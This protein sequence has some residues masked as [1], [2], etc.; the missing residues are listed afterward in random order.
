[1]QVLIGRERS[2]L[3]TFKSLHY[4]LSYKRA[5]APHQFTCL[6]LSYFI[7]HISSKKKGNTLRTL[8][9]SLS[10]SEYTCLAW[11]FWFILCMKIMLPT[12]R[13]RFTKTAKCYSI[14]QGVSSANWSI[15]EWMPFFIFHSSAGR[16]YQPPRWW[17]MQEFVWVEDAWGKLQ[18]F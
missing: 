11:K 2:S 6:Y 16:N 4:H 5:S 13:H 14:F 18:C 17:L 9:R 15:L 10:V 8:L 1:M 12:F 7:K 3:L